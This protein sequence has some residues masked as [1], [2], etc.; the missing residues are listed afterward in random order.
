MG[1]GEV[2]FFP[3]LEFG[4]CLILHKG[5][6]RHFLGLGMNGKMKAIGEK[7]PKAEAHRAVGFDNQWVVRGGRLGAGGFAGMTPQS[8]A[9]SRMPG[10]ALAYCAAALT[11]K[12]P[13]DMVKGLVISVTTAANY[14]CA[15]A[16]AD[17]DPSSPPVRTRREKE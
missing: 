13:T 12:P 7:G 11:D 8:H 16:A 2:A 5:P 9:A 17:R 3:G 10:S 6:H 15:I 1:A 4:A 14:G